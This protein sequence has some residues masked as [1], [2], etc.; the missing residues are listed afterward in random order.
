MIRTQVIILAGG[1]GKR[2]GGELP[3][4][5]VPLNGK[6]L[7]SY[8]LEAIEHSGV[9]KKPVIVIGNQAEKV[10]ETLGS[11]YQYVYQSERKGTGHA[12]K[13]CKDALLGKS[14]NI[15]ILYGDHPFVSSDIIQKLEKTHCETHS[16]VTFM[17]VAVADFND[18]RKTFYSF[19]RIVRDAQG[20]LQSIIELK[21]ANEDQKKI[22][23]LNPSFFCFKASWLWENI[24]KLTNNNAQ[25]EYYLTDL[26]GMAIQQKEK[27]SAI[28][29]DP[30]TAL[31]INTPEELLWAQ[32]LMKNTP[33]Q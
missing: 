11:R 6:P 32:K 12:V 31:G 27:V 10:K 9:C 23:E 20:A 15:L 5:F 13:I 4:V 17:T 8:L 19:G 1:Q 28:S 18:W 22:H 24:E 14:E 30:K 26:L 29:V 2:M 33:S 7:V 3:K 25:K 21:D 16:I